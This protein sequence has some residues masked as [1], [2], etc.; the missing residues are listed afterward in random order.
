MVAAVFALLI[1]P[2]LH[3]EDERGTVLNEILADLMT[4]ALFTGLLGP[5]FGK[6]ALSANYS[7]MSF[8]AYEADAAVGISILAL[9]LL[10][11][12][13]YLEN[14]RPS[15]EN[16]LVAI[17]LVDNAYNV[18]DEEAAAEPVADP[19]ARRLKAIKL[20]ERNIPD[21]YKDAIT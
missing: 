5:V 9:P 11:L 15:L 17:A 3:F 4:I 1:A 16:N 13:N 19:F 8:G 6:L 2:F 14:R 20:D 7:T 10:K 12:I 21:P 18:L